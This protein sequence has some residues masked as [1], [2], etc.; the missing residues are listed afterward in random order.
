MACFSVARML[1]DRETL[2]GIEDV[3]FDEGRPGRGSLQLGHRSGKAEPVQHFLL[4]GIFDILEGSVP[5][6]RVVSGQERFVE[7]S[8]AFNVGMQAPGLVVKKCVGPA[9][10][11]D[12]CNPI[13]AV[14]ENTRSRRAQIETSLRGR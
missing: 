6:F 1:E 10:R 8:I 4:P 12:H 14:L 11:C 9:G 13:R 2:V 7:G 3:A 5:P